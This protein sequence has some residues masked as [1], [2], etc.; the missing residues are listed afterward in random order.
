MNANAKMKMVGGAATA[1]N[2]TTSFVRKDQLAHLKTNGCLH[3]PESYDFWILALI[4]PHQRKGA[5]CAG[6]LSASSPKTPH[7]KNNI[8]I[9]I[10]E[11]NTKGP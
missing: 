6:V 1:K 4:R 2:I 10:N 9:G 5:N 7:E 11:V 8:K 3:A